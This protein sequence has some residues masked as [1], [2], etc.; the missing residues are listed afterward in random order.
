LRCFSG[1]WVASDE[2][3]VVLEAL[4]VLASSFSYPFGGKDGLQI[5][6]IAAL[7]H[8]IA[9]FWRYAAQ[10]EQEWDSFLPWVKMASF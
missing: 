9:L 4:V 10:E 5:H 7:T 2:P 8:I 1:F 6:I 3:S